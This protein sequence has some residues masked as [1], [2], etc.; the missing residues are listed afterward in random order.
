MDT[1]RRR[2]ARATGAGAGADRGHR[3]RPGVLRSQLPIVPTRA[4]PRELLLP[5]GRAR[6]GHRRSRPAGPAVVARPRRPP[7]RRRATSRRDVHTVV[8]TH[9]H[10]DHFGGAGRLRD[11]HGAEVVT[12]RS[13]RTWFDPAE[14]EAIVD[15][16]TPSR[17]RRRPQAAVGPGDARGAPTP[18]LPADRR[19][20]KCGLDTG[21][22]LRGASCARRHRRAASTTREVITLARPRVGVAAHARAHRRPPLPVRPRRRHRALRRPRA[23]HDHAAHLGPGRGRPI[24][25]TAFFESLDKVAALDGVR[26]V[27]PAHGHPFA[28][29][30]RVGPTTIK[31]HHDERLDMLRNAAGRA[32]VGHASRSSRT[33]CSSR[34]SWGPMAESETYAH[35]EHLRHR[36]GR[37]R[38]DDAATP[39][40][41][42]RSAEPSGR[43]G[44]D[45]AVADRHPHG[46]SPSASSSAVDHRQRRRA[47][48]RRGARPRPAAAPAG[49]A[50]RPAPPRPTS[51]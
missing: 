9:S 20:L 28:R 7:R 4:R 14:N 29:P 39:A 33:T 47:R 50:G 15:P 19:R 16:T 51:Q 31:E 45:R 1:H 23:A 2:I 42:A 10:P 6:R 48:R 25:S 49:R 11:T 26:L 43:R 17:R 5:R 41:P 46:D 21:H 32:R 38:R 44:A 8:V 37:A 18:R 36:R 30:R 22:A 27:L 24:R 13:F 12:H 40:L 3:G 35:L 34:A